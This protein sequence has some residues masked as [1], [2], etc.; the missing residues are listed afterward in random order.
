M[1]ITQPTVATTGVLPL[2]LRRWQ[3]NLGGDRAALDHGLS[4]LIDAGFIWIDI[5]NEELLIRSWVKHNVAGRTKM[6]K[7]A[8]D[9]VKGISSTTIKGHLGAEYPGLFNDTIP[10]SDTPSDTSSI[11]H[12]EY[13]IDSAS[14]KC[15]VR[16]QWSEASGPSPS[17]TP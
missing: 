7:A 15:V 14:G 1:L 9:Q 16:G 8:Q 17:R 13:P 12:S 4:V 5:E 10:S 2:T 6:E 3:K 11:H